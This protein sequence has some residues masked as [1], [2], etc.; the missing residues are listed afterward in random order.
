MKCF[1]LVRFDRSCAERTKIKQEARHGS[2]RLVR[3]AVPRAV[4]ILLPSADLLPLAGA[5][6]MQLKTEALA[7]PGFRFLAKPGSLFWVS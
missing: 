2:A 4:A 7:Q 6:Q 1:V 5:Q 3:A